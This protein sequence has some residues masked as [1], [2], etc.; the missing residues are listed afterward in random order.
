MRKHIAHHMHGY[1]SVSMHVMCLHIGKICTHACDVFTHWKDLYT[2]M[3][4]MCFTH[5]KL[6]QQPPSQY[7][8]SFFTV[9]NIELTPPKLA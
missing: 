5:W 8:N 6:K 3:H 2:V 9:H 1:R 7:D 4:E